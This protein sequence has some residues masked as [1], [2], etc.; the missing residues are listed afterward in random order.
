MEVTQVK[1]PLGK[2]G[3]PLASPRGAVAEGI[4]DEISIQE[5]ERRGEGMRR[6]EKSRMEWKQKERAG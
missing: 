5:Y 1:K 3:L 4:K 2:L 6:S